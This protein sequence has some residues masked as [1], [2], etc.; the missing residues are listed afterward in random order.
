[1][2]VLAIVFLQRFAVASLH[3]LAVRL[4]H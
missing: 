1:V 3:D 4:A 2:V